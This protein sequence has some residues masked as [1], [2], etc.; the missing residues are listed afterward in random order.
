MI[1]DILRAV[2]EVRPSWQRERATWPHA[3]HSSF[4]ARGSIYWH[5]QMMG[6]GPTLLLVHGT[7]A[8]THSF[9]ALMPL[10]A[11]HFTVVAVDLPGH[12]FSQIISD[13][14]VP[15]L[16]GTATAL[17]D[18]LRALKLSPR[19]CVGH[20]AGAAV[21]AQM[22]IDHQIAPEL[23]VGLGAALLPIRGVAAHLASPTARALSRSL[24]AAPLIASKARDNGTIERM[25]QSV[26][27]SLDAQGVA[28]YRRL[29]TY[30]GHVAA[31][32]AMLS[33]WDLSALFAELP[34]IATRFLLLA[35]A[36]DAAVPLTQQHEIAAR[37]PFAELVVIEGAGHLL[38]EEQ[39]ERV[40]EMIVNAMAVNAP[41]A[42]AR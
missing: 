21:I 15:S 36:D 6:N 29:A 17:A 11:H 1:R 25:L 30:P 18:L 8:S 16:A 42:A 28:L 38:H 12:A 2:L 39:P 35:G 19:V 31:V 14:F 34:H 20:S 10:L 23:I 9:R 40:A 26:G 7:G 41:L 32:L 13:G 24:V 22:A 37:M 3:E 4:I 27:S 5:V 33:S